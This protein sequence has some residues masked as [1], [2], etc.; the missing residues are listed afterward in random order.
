M[1]Q[2]IFNS[3]SNKEKTEAIENLFSRSV[4][5]LDFFLMV[6]FSVLM[7][8]LGLLTNSSAVIVGSMLIA[9]MLYPILG[10]SMGII[11][12]DQSLISKS[13]LT[14]LRASVLAIIVSAIT[15]FFFYSQ[16]DGVSE[17]IILRTQPS[18]FTAAIGI[19]AGFAAAFAMVKPKLNETLPGVAVSV[20]L[21]PPLA[22]VGIG[23]AELNMDIFI[24]ALFLFLI[25]A[26]GVIFAA[27]IVFSLMN[28]YVKR[29]VAKD[30]V[31]K[32]E[33]KMEDLVKQV[34]D[35]SEE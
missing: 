8:T 33:K 10:I 14:M 5:S 34:D 2:Q 24:N 26:A 29:G 3:V 21:V 18:L 16:I 20:A 25:N 13:F 32:E 11:M 19:V 4:P 17:E 27:A 30:V 7:A 23:I 12:S 15:A 28:F 31:E 22:V 1:F 9:P 35:R 6:I